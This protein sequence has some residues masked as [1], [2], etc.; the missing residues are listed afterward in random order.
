M[1]V[2]GI[3]E[4]N[5]ESENERLLRRIHVSTDFTHL[6]KLHD[7]VLRNYRVAERRPFLEAIDIRM[8]HLM[9]LADVTR[10]WRFLS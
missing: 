8:W 6:D 10:N 7:M 1:S 9:E 3:Q 2:N 4:D 5:N